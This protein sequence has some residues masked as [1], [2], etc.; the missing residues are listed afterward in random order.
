MFSLELLDLPLLFCQRSGLDFQVGAK[1]CFSISFAK[2]NCKNDKN[3]SKHYF[4]S[5]HIARRSFNNAI[6]WN[7]MLFVCFVCLFCLF[8]CLVCL[9]V[10]LFV[11]LCMYLFVCLFECTPCSALKRGYDDIPWRVYFNSSIYNTE[12]RN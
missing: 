9:F 2:L 3:M 1:H 12:K 11:C 6:L 5:S 10:C 4:F 7:Q 8:V